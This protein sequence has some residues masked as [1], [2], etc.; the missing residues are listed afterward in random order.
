MQYEKLFPTIMR[1]GFV[2]NAQKTLVFIGARFYN[3]Y[4]R[5]LFLP[6]FWGGT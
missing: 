1:S 4:R 6:A 3:I 5:M 2:H